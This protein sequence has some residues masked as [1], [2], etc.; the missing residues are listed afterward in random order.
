MMITAVIVLSVVW[1]GLIYFIRKALFYE[2]RKSLNG[3]D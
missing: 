1:G 3:K 2:K